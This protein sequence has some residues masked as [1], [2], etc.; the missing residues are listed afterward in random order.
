MFTRF[1]TLLKIVIL[2]VL[3]FSGIIHAAISVDSVG[4]DSSN[5]N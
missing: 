1:G 4:P 5:D 2:A 3:A